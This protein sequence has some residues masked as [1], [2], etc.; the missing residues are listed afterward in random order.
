MKMKFNFNFQL[1]KIDYTFIK[2][3]YEKNRQKVLTVFVVLCGIFFIFYWT[4]GFINSKKSEHLASAAASYE[5]LEKAAVLAAQIKQ[6]ELAGGG[7]NMNMGLLAFVQTTGSNCGISNKLINIRPVT[8]SGNIEH[9][10]LRMENLFYD[11][12]INF[13]SKIEAYNNLKVKTLN[14]SRRYDNS[15]MIDASMEIIKS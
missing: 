13:I 2:D 1:K 8:A 12:F 6:G 9:V 10:S 3:F 7:N 11:E 14:F 4:A 15:S 5:R